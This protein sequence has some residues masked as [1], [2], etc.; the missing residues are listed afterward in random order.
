MT[1]TLTTLITKVQVLL[2]DDGTIF[3]TALCTGAIRKALATVNQF[4]PVHAGELLDTVADQYEYELSD[5]DSA[6]MRITDV[7]LQGDDEQDVSLDYDGYDEDE[8]VFFRLRQ[9][10]PAGEILIVRYVKPHTVNGLDS[11]TSSTLPAW[12]DEYLVIGAAAEA[13]MIR[14]RGRVESINLSQDQSDNYRELY[15]QLN[16]EFLALLRGVSRSKKI[17]VGVPDER[18]WND[19]YHTWGQ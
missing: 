2:D 4:M 9:S 13:V 5:Y 16:L 11:E 3:T 17:P 14:A 7:L 1:D 10:Q 18:A 15:Q 6:A 12:Q 8:R 19:Q